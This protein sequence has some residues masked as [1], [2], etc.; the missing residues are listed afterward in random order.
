[1]NNVVETGGSL[2]QAILEEFDLS[3]RGHFL[4][5]FKACRMID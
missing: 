1:M 5:M 4:L 2:G 3:V